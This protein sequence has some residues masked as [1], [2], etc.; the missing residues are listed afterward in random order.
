MMI[1]IPDLPPQYD[2]SMSA[3]LPAQCSS[4]ANQGTEGANQESPTGNTRTQDHWRFFSILFN[5]HKHIGYQYLTI[6][7]WINW[8]DKESLLFLY[9]C[10]IQKKTLAIKSYHETCD[11]KFP[12]LLGFLSVRAVP[13][14]LLW[15]QTT[16]NQS[17]PVDWTVD[18]TASCK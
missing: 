12:Q 2:E 17:V 14:V 3:N 4:S 7:A 11:D 8:L 10:I 5:Q 13:S 1:F 6:F 16:T 15:R 9:I 18:Y